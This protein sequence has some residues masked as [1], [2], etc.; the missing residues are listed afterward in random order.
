MLYLTAVCPTI[1]A[2]FLHKSYAHAS[3]GTVDAASDSTDSRPSPLLSEAVFEA[4]PELSVNVPVG[5][6]FAS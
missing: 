1:W 3:Y 4:A 6:R 5:G 2:T